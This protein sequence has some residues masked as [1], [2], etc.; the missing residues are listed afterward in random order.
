MGGVSRIVTASTTSFLLLLASSPMCSA[1]TVFKALRPRGVSMYPTTPMH[2]MGGVS[3]IV[4]A[5]T[6][7]FLLTLEPG[8]SI[9]L[10]MCHASFVTH[11]SCQMNRLGRIILGKSLDLSSMP[12]GSLLGKKSLR[13]VTWC[14]ELP[15]RHVVFS[16]CESS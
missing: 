3:R 9:S 2:I 16:R 10:T 1:Q 4:P 5:S 8:L 14:L 6:T 11:E 13:T 7:S 12:L 15:V